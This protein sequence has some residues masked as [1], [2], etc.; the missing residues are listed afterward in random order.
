[1]CMCLIPLSHLGCTSHNAQAAASRD[2]TGGGLGRQQ[3]PA[4]H[5]TLLCPGYMQTVDRVVWCGSSRSW[6]ASTQHVLLHKAQV[7]ILHPYCYGLQ[8][9]DHRS[10][11]VYF[12]FQRPGFSIA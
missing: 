5:T 10:T 9:T 6:E 1:M 11:A 4:G 2:Y 8:D 12:I 3:M 7:G